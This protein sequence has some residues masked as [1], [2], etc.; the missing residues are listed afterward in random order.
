MIPLVVQCTVASA[1]VAAKKVHA[2]W[3]ETLW[4][5]RQVA[6]AWLVCCNLTVIFMY[7][8]I[9]HSP[10]SQP[11]IRP[12]TSIF[13]HPRLQCAHPGRFL[14]M[15]PLTEVYGSGSSQRS[16]NHGGLNSSK[17]LN[18]FGSPFLETKFSSQVGNLAHFS[19]PLEFPDFS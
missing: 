1:S 2:I 13:S 15:R 17:G 4:S 7:L 18:S 19:V 8:F 3:I 12:L 14:S 9:F 5:W 10:S 11:C 16:N 6:L